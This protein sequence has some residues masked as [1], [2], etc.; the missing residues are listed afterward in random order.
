MIAYPGFAFS[1]TRRISD[2]SH[3]DSPL[4]VFPPSS[5]ARRSYRDAMFATLVTIM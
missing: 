3:I 4:V 5:L 1:R 2:C